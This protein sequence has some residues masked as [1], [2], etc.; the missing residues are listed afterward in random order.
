MQVGEGGKLFGNT[1]VFKGDGKT[2]SLVWQRV[3]VKK[4]LV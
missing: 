1:C 4:L 2:D 3:L